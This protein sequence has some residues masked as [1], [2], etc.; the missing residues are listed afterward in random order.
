MARGLCRF[1]LCPVS[2]PE[3]RALLASQP[4]RA[5]A[6]ALGVPRSTVSGWRAR[7]GMA[8]CVKTGGLRVLAAIQAQPGQSLATLARALGMS[9]E[10]MRQ[11]VNRLEARG[12]VTTIIRQQT[13][14]GAARLRHCWAVEGGEG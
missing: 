9:R 14:W 5:V 7:L 6:A 2:E 4:D 8:P 13:R 3:L 11:A 12:L 1:R 10:G